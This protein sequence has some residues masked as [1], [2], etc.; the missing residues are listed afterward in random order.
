MP[1]RSTASTPTFSDSTMFSLK[2]L[3]RA[4]SQRFLL[5]R[6]VQLRII[7]RDGHV[8]RDR[9]HQ[10]HVVAREKIAVDGLP[11]TKYGDGVLANAAGNKIVQIQLLESAGARD[12]PTSLAARGDSKKSAP[13]AN[14]GRAGSR[15]LR[16]MGSE[17]RTP[18]ERA[19]RIFRVAARLP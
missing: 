15:K 2:S 8:A 11:K 7:E 5:E 10:L 3:S 13:R 18:I 14:S 1:P 6:A 19:R 17:R 12:S 16:S 4:I 9:L